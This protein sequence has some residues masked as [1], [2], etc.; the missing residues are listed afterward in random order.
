MRIHLHLNHG[1]SRRPTPTFGDNVP[2]SLTR[3]TPNGEL[4]LIELQGS[5]EMSGLEDC[6]EGA[7]LLGTLSFEKGISEHP[8]L[9]V[10]HHRLEGKIVSLQKPLAVLEKK[11]RAGKESAHSGEKEGDQVQG[12]ANVMEETMQD[13]ITKATRRGARTSR[14]RVR[15]DSLMSNA[16]AGEAETDPTNVDECAG[17]AHLPSIS[18]KRQKLDGS[19]YLE[20]H[21]KSSSLIRAPAVKD[22]LDF[23]SS[24]THATDDDWS[25]RPGSSPLQRREGLARR[26][27]ADKVKAGP[28][29]TFYEVVSIVR[30]KII[31]SKRPEP[32]VKNR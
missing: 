14:V 8:V 24:P 31:F 26:S 29:S 3:L 12:T 5:L 32:H 25:S 10:S 30:K 2:S 15:A 23:S 20:K 9:T 19:K 1:S 4:V 7:Q 13:G 28:T 16:S 17:T 18:R 6:G 11:R 27:T 21:H 22:A